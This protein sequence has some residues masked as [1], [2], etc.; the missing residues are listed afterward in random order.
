MD[1]E[2]DFSDVVGFLGAFGA[3]SPAADLDFSGGLDFSDVVLF[4]EAFG[5]A[6][7]P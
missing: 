3:G 5:E 1:G 7:A 6:T 2:V 4:L